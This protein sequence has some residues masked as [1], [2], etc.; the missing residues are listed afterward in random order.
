MESN[1]FSDVERSEEAFHDNWAA[2]TDV[3]QVKVDELFESGSCPENQQILKWMGDI[4]GKRILEIGCGL[5]EASVYFAKQGAIVTASDI[6]G[7]ML[8]VAARLARRHNAEISTIQVS[9][10]NLSAIPNHTYDYIYAANLL[11]HVDIQTFI[12]EAKSKLKP[13][14]EAFFWD[15]VHYNPVIQIYRKMATQVRTE[16][17]HPLTRRD[18]ANIRRSFSSCEV[19]FF[20]F[21][22]LAIFVKFFLI[23]RIHPNQSRY[24]K[25]IID[26]A[27]RIGGVLS[28]LHAL[29]KILFSWIPGI[30]WL[31]WNIVM[32]C[33]I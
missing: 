33:R 11:H 14:G 7:G 23:D 26:D 4:K 30:R 25:K 24:W 5:G 13:G 29:D 8:D 28:V 1:P 12:H 17:E 6:S 2:N 20:W 31:G 3:N 16:D 22:A 9:A 19:K 18:L 32:R 21:T 15:P 10:Q 27:P